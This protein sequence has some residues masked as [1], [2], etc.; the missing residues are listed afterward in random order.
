MQGIII[1]CSS[2]LYQI[3]NKENIYEATPRGKLKKEEMTPVVGD[4]VEFEI[5]DQEKDKQ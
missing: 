3:N 2:N 1:E 4:K 5:T